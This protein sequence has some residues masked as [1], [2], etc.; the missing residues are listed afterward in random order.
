MVQ[1]D[2]F[3]EELK[4]L[5]DAL[6]AG[7]HPIE[8]DQRFIGE[9]AKDLAEESI[10]CR[11][12]RLGHALLLVTGGLVIGFLVYWIGRGFIEGDKAG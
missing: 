4:A 1:Q 2:I 3:D 6:K 10:I 7:L 5:E 12:R 9:L 8:P 11:Q